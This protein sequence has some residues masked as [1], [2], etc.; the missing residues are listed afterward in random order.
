MKK[1]LI[2][3]AALAFAVAI[4]TS[5]FAGEGKK[6]NS[7][8]ISTI[9]D[10]SLV[11]ANKKAGTDQTFKTGADTKVVKADGSAGTLSDLKSG[12]HVKVTAGSAPDQAAEIQIVEHKK[13]D[14]GDKPAKS[15]KA[16]E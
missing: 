12:A 8:K 13:K 3:L 15:T 6:P 4:A 7:G 9:S 11:I 10:G 5:S 2:K 16:N 14:D 1:S